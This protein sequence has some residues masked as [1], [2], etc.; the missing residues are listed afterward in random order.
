[1]IDLVLEA[2][3]RIAQQC[4]HDKV[5]TEHVLRGMLEVGLIV[6]GAQNFGAMILIEQGI[7]YDQVLTVAEQIRPSEMH[8]GEIELS[9]GT[10]LLLGFAAKEAHDIGRQFNT[11]HLL[12]IMCRHPILTATKVLIKLNFNLNCV[13]S[14]AVKLRNPH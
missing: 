9:E 2:A 12:L 11:D 1:M 8:R 14:A 6:E 3:K 13:E 4:G 5:Q 10:A 7:T